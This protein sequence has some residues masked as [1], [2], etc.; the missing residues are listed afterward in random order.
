MRQKLSL[1]PSNW[2]SHRR[3]VAN[4]AGCS[5]ANPFTEVWRKMS[6]PWYGAGWVIFSHEPRNK[7][8][9]KTPWA[10]PNTVTLQQEKNT[11]DASFTLANVPLLTIRPD[12]AQAAAY[13][14]ALLKMAVMLTDNEITRE[15]SIFYTAAVRRCCDIFVFVG[16]ASGV[17]V[18]RLS[19]MFWKL[20]DLKMTALL[21]LQA[22]P[23]FLKEDICWQTFILCAWSWLTHWS[24]DSW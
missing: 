4:T 5:N 2:S 17:Y 13:H 14:K 21:S 23:R 1:M 6:C 11:K 19:K 24:T 8:Q 12:K 18:N 3:N 22:V 10:K 16:D 7:E 9:K 15:A 20:F